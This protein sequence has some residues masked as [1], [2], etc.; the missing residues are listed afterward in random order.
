MK[1]KKYLWT[2][3]AVYMCYLTQGIQAIAI[4][5]NLDQFTA[6]W[7][8][9]KAGVYAI[10][11][12]TGLARFLSVWICGELSNKIGRKL[13]ISIGVVMY[14]AFFAGLLTATSFA[15][16]GIY[17]FIGGL[18]TSFVD[19]ACY[20]AV[21]ESRTNSSSS[22]V[23]LKGVIS[24]SG[25]V[26]PLVL[27]SF[28]A[29][30]I[31]QFGLT[32]PIAMSAI[33]LVLALIAPYSYDEELHKKRAKRKELKAAGKKLAKL[34]ELDEGAQRAAARIVKKPP[35]IVNTGCVLFGF[36]AM[37]I[38]YSAQQLL[39]RHGLTVF[40]M[41][42]L[43]S[44]SLISLYT[45]GSLFAVI[46]SELMMAKFCWR[47][48]KLLLIDLTGSVIAYILLY[49]ATSNVVV[50]ISAVAIGI[51]AAGGA[52]QR[53]V[54]LMLEFHPG[55]KARNLG[56]YYTFMGLAS[57]AIPKI[58]SVFTKTLGEGQAITKSLFVT[59][60]LAMIGTVFAI[61]LTINYKRW[62]GVSPFSKKG[63]EK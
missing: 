30:G 38:M 51:F 43:K 15:V 18:A 40:G 59:L 6:Q 36:F 25:I 49:T 28:R 39:S 45:F 21:Q 42:D 37:A 47:T 13:M 24:I 3:A 20:P 34:N 31:W 60:V 17:A 7:S 29:K 52:L 8:T 32:I 41:S 35:F 55:N 10:I 54:S 1:G 63:T 33:V 22:S 26:Y 12:Y 19:G 50:Q 53:G 62:F 48:L 27:V 57:Y 23:I 5:Q 9:D 11:A 46:V 2:I 56:L 61:Y 14:V 4:S 16:A 44:S 58:Q